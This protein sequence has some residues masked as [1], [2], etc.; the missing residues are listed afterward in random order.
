MILTVFF[1]ATLVLLLLLHPLQR[2]LDNAGGSFFKAITQA[3]SVERDPFYADAITDPPFT[4]LT[5]SVQ[6]FL[7]WDDGPAALHLEWIRLMGFTHVKQTFAWEDI[8][9]APDEWRWENG[10]RLMGEVESKGLEIIVRLGVVPD[11]AHPSLPPHENNTL[12]VDAPPDDLSLWAAYCGAVA[13]RYAGRVQAYQIWNE[14]NLTREWGGQEPNPAAFVE[15]LR[16]CSEAIRAADPDAVLISPGLSPTGDHN[17]RAYRDDIYLQM[18]YDAGFEQHVDVVGVHAPGYAPPP[19]GPDDAERDGQGRWA[20]FR[21]VEDLRKIMIR[22]GDAERQMAI[23][24]TGYTT[25]TLNPDYMWFA[26]SEEEQAQYLAEAYRYAAEHWR[27]WVGLMSSVYIAKAIWT[28]ADEQFWWAF[29]DPQTGRMRPVFGAM[30]QMEK[31]CGD[32]I[33]PAR[34]PVESAYAPE[35]N[36]CN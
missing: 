24:E 2:S 26:V 29:N 5:Y 34:D 27:P 7:W 11:W 15:M 33:F 16:L 19:Y 28:P 22:N 32:I 8:Q 17:A 14:P 35:Y 20:T 31:Y 30:A 21:R 9:P 13:T 4:S 3:L 36:P 12:Y 18:M 25:D 23:L 6:A 1:T 10:D